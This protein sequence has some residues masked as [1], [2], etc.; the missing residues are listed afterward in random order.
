[1]S[2]PLGNTAYVL[3]G[4]HVLV[5]YRT[6]KSGAKFFFPVKIYVVT[7]WHKYFIENLYVQFQQ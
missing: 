1:M 7:G 6:K 2:L 4:I 3:Y 5:A